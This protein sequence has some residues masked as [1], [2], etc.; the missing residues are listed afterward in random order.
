MDSWMHKIEPLVKNFLKVKVTYKIDG[1][2]YI[3]F[4]KSKLD[5]DIYKKDVFE[6][7]T[8]LHYCDCCDKHQVNK[9]C[10]PVKWNLVKQ[11]TETDLQCVCDCRHTARMICRICD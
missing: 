2:D 5:L 10:I 11:P 1:I 8:N 6:I 4:H 3:N 9:P 7:L